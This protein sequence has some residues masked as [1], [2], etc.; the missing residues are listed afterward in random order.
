MTDL[1]DRYGSDY[2]IREGKPNESLVVAD[3][4]GERYMLPA[5][6][7]KPAWEVTWIECHYTIVLCVDARVP[8]PHRPDWAP[9]RIFNYQLIEKLLRN[10]DWRERID[11]LIKY[12]IADCERLITDKWLALQWPPDQESLTTDAP[13]ARVEL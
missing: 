7:Y 4:R 6:K 3:D 10:V 8:I 11:Y 13:S 5:V 12:T 9:E 1:Y 2:F